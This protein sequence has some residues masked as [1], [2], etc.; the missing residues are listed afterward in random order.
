MDSFLCDEEWLPSPS[1]TASGHC[2]QFQSNV[3]VDSYD[4]SFYTTKEDCEQALSLCLEKELSYMPQQ[5]YF[6]HLQSKNLFF[7][8]FKAVQWLI[9][10][11]SRLNLSFETL[12]NAANY[13]DRFISLNKCL[14]WKN[15]MVEL[16]SVACLSVA[17]KFSE[18]TYAPSLL[19][20][21]MED[22][23]HTFQSITIQ[24]MELMLLQALGWRLGSTTVYSYVELMMMMMVINN[25]FLKSHLRKDLI[26]ARVTELILGTIL[27][28]KF[29][30]FRPSIAAVSAIWC[31]LEELIPSKT[32][33]QLTYITGFLNKD[34]KD[35]IVKCHNILE[36]KLID[37][38]NDLAACENSSYCPSSPV[39]VLLTERIDVYDCHVD[40]SLFKMPSSNTNILESTN[41]RRKQEANE[42]RN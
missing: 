24:R 6:E 5:G 16:L 40:L 13:L 12:F 39:T 31:G 35:D 19:E 26:V 8:R 37:P 38:L 30:E 18:S 21:Q 23:D 36:Q 33:T 10:S 3:N 1:S 25:D 17:S 32:S 41:K 15:W 27:D 22:M 42:V 4:D 28:C 29:A 9:K 20:I 11:R 14:E 2:T 7:A 34:Q